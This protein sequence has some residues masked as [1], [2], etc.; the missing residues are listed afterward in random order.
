[1]LQLFFLLGKSFFLLYMAADLTLLKL[2]IGF[3]ALGLLWSTILPPLIVAV[4]ARAKKTLRSP[5][6]VLS[7]ESPSCDHSDA[8]ISIIVPVYNSSKEL[9][10][11]LS[12]LRD[13]FV[14][15]GKLGGATPVV[16]CDGK[17]E[18]SF[19]RIR[20]LVVD[21]GSTD[22]SVQVAKKFGAEVLELPKNLG[23][24]SALV[25]G[26]QTVLETADN[27]ARAHW[28]G[29]VDAGSYWP[30]DLVSKLLPK[31]KDPSL[32]GIAPRYVNMR[33]NFIGKILWS[34]ESAIK[35]FEAMGRGPTSVHG[36]TVF[37]R[38]DVLQE[39]LSILLG[40][41]WLNDDVVLP[42]LIRACNPQ[43]RIEYATD[44]EVQDVSPESSSVSTRN[45][46]ARMMKG[47]IQWLGRLFTL[48]MK[49]DKDTCLVLSRRAARIFWAY[50]IALIATGVVGL[51]LLAALPESLSVIAA[52]FYGS[53]AAR[54]SLQAPAALFLDRFSS[55]A[56][57]GGTK[58]C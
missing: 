10:A 30:K 13:S 54:A 31:L 53:S 41:T 34:F 32:V 38:A 11:T 55:Q 52:I 47:N 23:K 57:I 36:A 43:G 37:Y 26:I 35:R 4:I 2:C 3:G 56:V 21:D 51:I 45:R 7:E 27:E 48:V 49:R 9:E 8:C 33:A 24:W 25:A 17:V 12:S 39:P 1:V 46:R 15:T 50:W 40:T 6:D 42:L 19:S 29:L 20:V 22:D 58:W 28:V 5:L 44:L 16:G 18:H 14:S